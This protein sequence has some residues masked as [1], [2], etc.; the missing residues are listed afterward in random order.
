MMP[1]VLKPSQKQIALSPIEIENIIFSDGIFI[2]KSKVA[3][4]V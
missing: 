4:G 3:H 1:G 2:F